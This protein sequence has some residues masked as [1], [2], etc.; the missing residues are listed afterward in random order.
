MGALEE[1]ADDILEGGDQLQAP[2]CGV[3]QPPFFPAQYPA[4]HKGNRIDSQGR[5]V[6]WAVCSGRRAVGGVQWQGRGLRPQGVQRKSEASEHRLVPGVSASSAF[7][8]GLFPLLPPSTHTDSLRFSQE[9]TFF[10]LSE[11]G[12]SVPPVL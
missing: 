4:Q 12:G 6:Q 3:H 10:V 5:G 9:S 2:L 8:G 7:A 11:T 1:G